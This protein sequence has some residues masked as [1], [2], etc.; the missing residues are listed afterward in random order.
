MNNFYSKL[1]LLTK[2]DK[3][4]TNSSFLFTDSVDIILTTHKKV[5][6]IVIM[7]SDYL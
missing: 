4:P 7:A 3:E 6:N 2:T 1:T 5:V